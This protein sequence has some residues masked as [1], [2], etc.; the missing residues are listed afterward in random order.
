[1]DVREFLRLIPKVELHCH[2]EGTVRA[3]TA[4]DLARKHDVRLP[5][6][7][8]DQLYDYDNIVDFLRVYDAVSHAI[9]DRDDFA[10]VA[11]E[12]LEDGVE[13]G[14]LRY[15]EMFFN[16]TTHYQDGVTYE[17]VVDGLIDGI[18]AAEQDLG[19]RCRL[20]TAIHRGHGTDVAVDLVRTVLDTPRDEVIGIGQD[21]LTFPNNLEEPELFVEAY[22]VAA[23]GGLH[24]TA[25]VAE[26]DGSTPAN[27]ATALDQLGCERIDHGY[28]IVE[29]P[30]MVA[31]ARDEGV[32]FT[33]CPHSSVMLYGWDLATHPIREMYLQGLGVTFNTDDPPC[34]HTDLGKEYVEGIPGMGLGPDDARAIALNGVEATWLDDGEK[35]TLRQEFDREIDDLMSRL[36]A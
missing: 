17:T 24:R 14:S 12:S 4:F 11:Y 9:V 32:F 26:I 34:F 22:L 36:D 25:H 33:C 16:P 10:R 6:D 3:S 28:H 35:R 1:V 13:L 15:R 7:R 8:P 31:R 5:A 30:T 18:K 21:A 29:D 20:I 27:V 2:L 23:A 19:V